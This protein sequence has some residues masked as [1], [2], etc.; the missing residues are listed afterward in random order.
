MSK[1]Y[2]HYGWEVSYYSGKTRAYLRY[3]D[4]PFED[5]HP[6]MFAMR[7]ELKKRVGFTVMPVVVTPEDETWQDTTEIIDN[8]EARFPQASVYPDS[9]RQRLA[10]LLFELY[11][12]EWLLI[13]AMHYRWN[14]PEANEKFLHTEMGGEALPW[15]PGFVQRMLGRRIA[16]PL[17]AYLPFLGIT[18]KSIPAIE[19][20]AESVLDQLNR[21]FER[22]PY[23]FGSR[24]S[25]GDFGLMGPLYAHLSRDPWPRDNLIAPRPALKDWIERMQ[26]PPEPNAG[27]FLAEDQVPE[28][29]NP[30]LQNIFDELFPVLK[31][32]F[33]AVARWCEENPDKERLPR[34]VGRH[35]FTIR[36]VTET[37]SLRAFTQWMAQRPLDYY[38]SLAGAEKDAVDAWLKRIGGYEAMQMEIPQPLKREN[39]RLVRAA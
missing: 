19:A 21:H 23:L 16:A 17:N 38:R 32:T 3:K 30:I 8:F 39:F 35:E 29:L 24:P 10:A 15:A 25:I 36:G 5:I 34:G 14:F 7:G 37:R 6:S 27:E 13:P 31:D 9:P 22:Q 20:W 11:G 2:K 4:V 28:A 1:K 12:D 33:A 18:L 26:R